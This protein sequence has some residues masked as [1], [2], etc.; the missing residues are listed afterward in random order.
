MQIEL[1]ENFFTSHMYYSVHI[2][3]YTLYNYI[4]ENN[5]CENN[6]RAFSVDENI[7]TMKIKQITVLLHFLTSLSIISIYTYTNTHTHTH[8]EPCLSDYGIMTLSKT[9]DSGMAGLRPSSSSLTPTPPNSLS[10]W[11]SSAS[12]QGVFAYKGRGVA[13]TPCSQSVAELDSSVLATQESS[14]NEMDAT[15]SGSRV[16]FDGDRSASCEDDSGAICED[17]AGAVCVGGTGVAN[18]RSRDKCWERESPIVEEVLDDEVSYMACF[19][20]RMQI[21]TQMTGCLQP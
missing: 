19:L 11:S 3:E 7:F 1:N 9:P 15:T 16:P 6:F 21:S 10:K 13:Y 4:Q 8:T 5:F 14:L 2:H 18:D 17:D 12:S 20:G